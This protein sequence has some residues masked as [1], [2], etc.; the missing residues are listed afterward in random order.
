[1]KL[2]T[3]LSW[4]EVRN[5]L[6]YQGWLYLLF[7]VLA[8]GLTSLVYTQ[9][10]YRPPQDRRIDLYIRSSSAEQEQVN[11]FLEPVWRQAVPEMELVNAV[12]LMSAGGANDYYADMQLVTYIAAAEGDI[13]MLP[14]SEFK[15][16]ASQGAFVALDDAI[17]DG[18]VD[19][20]NLSL[21]AGRVKLVETDSDGT[22]TV[23]GEA[24]QYGIPTKELYNFATELL[25]DN[26][27]MVL[28]VAVNS[29]NEQ[30]ALTFLDALIQRARG[31]KPDFF[32]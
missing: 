12:L 2:R 15:R 22:T 8:F 1:M 23:V 7:C 6:R 16:F 31:E 30:A 28:A 20:S 5:H 9:T 11:A 10:A 4:H 24:R 21:A 3:K 27:D 29:G 13:Y 18:R 26:R 19:V 14:S 25:I 32:K 17:R